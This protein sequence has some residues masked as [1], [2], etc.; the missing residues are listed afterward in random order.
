MN[1]FRQAHFLQF[2]P[3][4]VLSSLCCVYADILLFILSIVIYLCFDW[5]TQ[6]LLLFSLLSLPVAKL[7]LSKCCLLNSMP[8]HLSCLWI[9]LDKI[10]IFPRSLHDCKFY[11]V[12][13][14]CIELTFG[15]YANVSVTCEVLTLYTFKTHSSWYLVY[16]C[17]GRKG[18]DKDC[19]EAIPQFKECNWLQIWLQA[20]CNVFE[21]FTYLASLYHQCISSSLTSLH[22]C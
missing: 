1:G 21:S 3:P 16:A 8:N 11:Y 7:L 17:T 14:T 4:T 19:T 18:V 10:F 20:R 5:T 9:K 22:Q 2:L 12:G 15:Q 6:N 13:Q